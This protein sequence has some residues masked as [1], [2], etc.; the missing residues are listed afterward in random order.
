MRESRT[1]K[2]AWGSCN[3]AEK[4]H[5]RIG[6]IGTGLTFTSTGMDEVFPGVQWVPEP[7]FFV[8]ITYCTATQSS[9]LQNGGKNNT[10]FVGSHK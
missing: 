1:L 3:R 5:Q 2:Q 10:L 4:G 7:Y 8:Q 6:V 9:H